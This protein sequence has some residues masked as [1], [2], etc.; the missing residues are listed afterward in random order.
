MAP[1]V[2]CVRD[3]RLCALGHIDLPALR[4]C[5][6]DDGCG[7]PGCCRHCQLCS[8]AV[9]DVVVVS[10]LVQVVALVVRLGCSSRRR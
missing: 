4:G 7:C 9:V 2:A 10:V 6:C 8:S 5:G 1:G 3:K